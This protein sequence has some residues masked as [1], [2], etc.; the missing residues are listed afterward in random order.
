MHLSMKLM[1]DFIKRAK[2]PSTMQCDSLIGTLAHTVS[3]KLCECW[4]IFN[5]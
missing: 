3:N 5:K 4:H 2:V 1:W